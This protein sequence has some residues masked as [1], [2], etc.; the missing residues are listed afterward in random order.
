VKNRFQSLPF[1]RNL[2][3]YITALA[4]LVGGEAAYGL[5]GEVMFMFFDGAPLPAEVRLGTFNSADPPSP[6][7][8]G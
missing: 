5:W 7:L 8:I 3:C 4:S 1:K 2:Q 6:R